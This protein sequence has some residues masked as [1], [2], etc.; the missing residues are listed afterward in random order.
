MD[1]S[2]HKYIRWQGVAKSPWRFDKTINK[3]RTTRFFETETDALWCKFIF[4]LT[5]TEKQVCI[6]RRLD[7]GRVLTLKERSDRSRFKHREKINAGQ[8]AFRGTERGRYHRNKGH[9]KGAGICEP[10]QGW[11]EF[12]YGTFIKATNCDV[13]DMVFSADGGNGSGKCLDHH[14]PSGYIR[15]IICRSCNIKRTRIDTLHMRVLLDLHRAS[16]LQS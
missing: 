9:W 11:E 14:H 15:H 12:Y 4:L 6:G 1:S 2:R 8:K 5:N 16:V 3:K 10:C 13:C 7:P